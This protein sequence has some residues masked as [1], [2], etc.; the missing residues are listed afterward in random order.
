MVTSSAIH[1]RQHLDRRQD[2]YGEP[3]ARHRQNGHSRP[4]PSQA[5]PLHA[6]RVGD[7]EGAHT[8]VGAKILGSGNSPFLKMGAEIALNRQERWN[9]GGY[10]HGRQGE[11]ILQT[12]RIMTI[13]DVYDALRSNRPCKP[14]HDPLKTVDIIMHGDARTRPEYFDPDILAASE[15]NHPLFCDIFDTYTV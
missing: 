3:G 5:G 7:H 12:A 1:K 9:G 11:A 15:L 13:R 10:P 6:G 4:Y 14:A 2:L 8:S